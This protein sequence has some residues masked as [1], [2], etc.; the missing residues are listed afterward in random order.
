M[1]FHARPIVKLLFTH[2]TR[3]RPLAGVRPDVVLQFVV[4][5]I[6]FVTQVAEISAHL[7][8]GV[9]RFAR[10]VH[11]RH[12]DFQRPAVVNLSDFRFQLHWFFFNV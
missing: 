1:L 11:F 2:L 9:F 12:V 5:C 3:K 8:H 4:R 10:L 7:L 6:C